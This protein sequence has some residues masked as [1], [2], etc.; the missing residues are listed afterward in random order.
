MAAAQD[1]KSFSHTMMSWYNWRYNKFPKNVKQNV[2]LSIIRTVH[3]QQEIYTYGRVKKKHKWKLWMIEWILACGF[4]RKRSFTSSRLVSFTLF[5]IL[6]QLYSPSSIQPGKRKTQCNS[7][8]Q[9]FNRQSKW[10]YAHNLS[11]K[12][13]K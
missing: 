1:L 5:V 10:I 2:T 13:N 6:L 4:L 8:Q 7:T 12:H 11:V 9:R 3:N